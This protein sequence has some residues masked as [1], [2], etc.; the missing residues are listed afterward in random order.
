MERDLVL[1]D[2]FSAC[3]TCYGFFCLIFLH[4]EL[5]L[6]FCVIFYSLWNALWYFVFHF[7]A[8]G[9]LSDILSYIF[10]LGECTLVFFVDVLYT[11]HVLT[12]SGIIFLYCSAC[13]TC[14]GIFCFF[15]S[16]FILHLLLYYTYLFI[17]NAF[18]KLCL[19][20]VIRS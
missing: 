8:F 5:T 15:F 14:S 1:C 9:M 3:G 2:I 17:F 20:Y 18:L 7:S 10:S 16:V 19:I 6:V 4:V 13:G 11:F 12:R